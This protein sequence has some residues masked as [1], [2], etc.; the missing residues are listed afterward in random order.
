MIRRLLIFLLVISSSSAIFGQ[1]DDFGIWYGLDAGISLSKKTDLDISGVIR[2]F[3]NASKIDQGYLETGISH[4]LSKYFSLAGSYRM[5]DKLEKD[6]RFHLRHRFMADIKGS[7]SLG[8]LSFSERLR[9][10]AQKRTYIE[11]ESDKKPEYHARLKFK[12]TYKTPK[13]P[14]NPYLSYESFI[15]LFENSDRFIDKNRYSAGFDFK[16]LKNQTLELEYTFQR[17]YAPHIEDISIASIN[18]SVN[19]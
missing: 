5:I 6:S 16:I 3:N 9:F 17:D 14:L 8:V 13:F 12:A 15:P 18:Y 11:D 2:T 4:K 19:F 1:D 10:Q 7:Y